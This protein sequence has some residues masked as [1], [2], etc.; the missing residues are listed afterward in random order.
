MT[1]MVWPRPQQVRQARS[2]GLLIRLG[3]MNTAANP[4]AAGSNDRGVVHLQRNDRASP[5]ARAPDDARA[6]FTPTEMAYPTLLSG[7]EQWR[8]PPTNGVLG[9]HAPPFVEVT[10]GTC[11]GQIINFR[12]TLQR[13]WPYMI[14]VEW[15]TGDE[16]L[17]VTILAVMI[18]SCGDL[19][20]QLPGNVGH[21]GSRQQSGQLIG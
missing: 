17:A 7:I 12:G 11:V 15:S 16:L 10:T 4:K 2:A 1:F 13:L 21:S 5:R 19:T 18:G 14:D 6:I 20:A 9:A 8:R 3:R